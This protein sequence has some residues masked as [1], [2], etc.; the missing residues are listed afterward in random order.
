MLKVIWINFILSREIECKI[1]I[2]YVCYV[3]DFFKFSF[4]SNSEKS[5]FH[6]KLQPIE[7]IYNFTNEKKWE[8][9]SK[10]LKY[11]SYNLIKIE[12]FL[13]FFDKI[14]EDNYYF[15]SRKIDNITI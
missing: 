15:C 11:N 10:I 5:W 13:I 1:N 7:V 12:P 8:K 14:N 6:L 4:Y 3:G 2:I 9:N